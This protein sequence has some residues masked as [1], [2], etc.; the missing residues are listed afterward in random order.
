LERLLPIPTV[1]SPPF[2]R[3][4]VP[5]RSLGVPGRRWVLGAF[6]ATLAVVTAFAAVIGAWPV[7]P[8]AGIEL[9]GLALAFRV[10][11]RHDADF[12]RLEVGESE[13]RW[14]ARD[15]QHV[16]CFV[17]HR[18]WARVVMKDSGAHCT[19]SLAYAGRTVPLGRMLSD[20][21]RRSLAESLRGKLPV[22]AY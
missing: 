15:A 9:A 20:E 22:T 3:F 1:D 11:A 19:L 17:A 5:N 4:W 10:L 6:A 18:P 21:G 8:F 13:V 2:V 7:L 14:E 12:E 16:T